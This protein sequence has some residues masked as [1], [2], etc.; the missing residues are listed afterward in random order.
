MAVL[1]VRENLAEGGVG[2]R[3]QAGSVIFGLFQ[4]EQA[5]H[6]IDISYPQ[7]CRLAWAHAGIDQHSNIGGKLFGFWPC[8]I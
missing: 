3:N 1:Q 7:L 4:K 8:G 6:L 5:A 2:E